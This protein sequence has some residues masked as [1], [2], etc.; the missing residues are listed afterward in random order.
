VNLTRYHGV[1]APH[2]R[3]RA[4]VTQTERGKGATGQTPTQDRTPAGRRAATTWA[5]RLKRV[6]RIDIETF[7][8][9][10]GAMRIIACIEGSA[11]IEK[12]LA[13]LDAKTA[14]AAAAQPPR[15]PPC[16]A[17]PGVAR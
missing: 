14:K 6:F 9:R 5:Q 8:A 4:R 16:R 17:P 12:T 2:S 7:A 1:F 3:H 15:S 11:V 10:G 13:N